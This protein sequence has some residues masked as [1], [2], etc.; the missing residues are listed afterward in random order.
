VKGA[1]EW[2]KVH[3]DTVHRNKVYRDKV[4]RDKVHRDTVHRDKVHRDKVHRDHH[5]SDMNP[6]NAS[7]I[8]SVS[9][10]SPN[11]SARHL[12]FAHA[13]RKTWLSVDTQI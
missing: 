13:F 7:S 2:D 4:H 3:R 8:P 10:S 1:S 6:L 11:Y 9:P 12:N 5:G